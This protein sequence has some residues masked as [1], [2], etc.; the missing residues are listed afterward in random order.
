VDVYRQL[1]AQNPSDTRLQSRLAQLEGHSAPES[2][3]EH[4]PPPVV[5]NVETPAP[6]GPSM[7]EILVR[8]AAARPGQPHVQ[9]QPVESPQA[10]V[11]QAD[12]SDWFDT[13]PDSPSEV[14]EIEGSS[15]PVSAPEMAAP[16]P[17][18]PAQN[19]E[20]TLAPAGSSEPAAS[21]RGID[22]LF[23]GRGVRVEEEA[24]AVALSGAFS[25][26][27]AA[28]VSGRPTRRASDEFSLDRV[29]SDA[30]RRTSKGQ[31]FSF[32]QFFSEG[33]SSQQAAAE[34]A[35]EP[36]DAD[37]AQFNSW[38]EGLKKK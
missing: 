31:N 38:L 16:A 2:A 29:F 17:L 32:N 5:S 26:G 1:L 12:D 6:R 7:R 23:G 21:P 11:T 33:G 13:P 10:V 19:E 36:G 9:V 25:N 20:S 8:I 35:N 14:P 4:Q 24:A 18:P 34:P 30:P 37:I 27:E 28:S 15:I 22:A 3:D